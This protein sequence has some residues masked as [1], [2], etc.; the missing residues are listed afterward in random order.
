MLSSLTSAPT[1]DSTSV[2]P[3]REK[4]T[5]SALLAPTIATWCGCWLDRSQSRTVPSYQPELASSFPSGEKAIELILL[6]WPVKVASCSREARSQIRISRL[7]PPAASLRP[8]GEKATAW[9]MS[10]GV[11]SKL[12]AKV[13]NDGNSA[14]VLK[15]HS[16]TR[17]SSPA[18]ASRRPSGEKQTEDTCFLLRASMPMS[19]LWHWP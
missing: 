17:P 18:A 14:R 19:S 16:R 2:L 3:S 6:V 12:A 4:A 10:R 7:G 15:S 8:S 5:Q 9:L 11:G 13:S 1:A